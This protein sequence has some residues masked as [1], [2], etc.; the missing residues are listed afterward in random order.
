M[1]FVAASVALLLTQQEQLPPVSTVLK[2]VRNLSIKRSEVDKMLGKPSAV[3]KNSDSEFVSYKAKG[4]TISVYYFARG[5]G[6]PLDTPF[7]IEVSFPK[8]TKGDAAIKLLGFDAAKVK[9]G[10]VDRLGNQY[11]VGHKVDGFDVYWCPEGGKY[12]DGNPKNSLK[13][14]EPFVLFDI[15][16]E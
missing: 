13:N 4:A 12:P 2:I 8:G 6:R 15:K 3:K 5:A 10:Q 1:S 14:G 9:L 7:P 16:S 11:L